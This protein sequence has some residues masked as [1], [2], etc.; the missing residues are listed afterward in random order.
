M[1]TIED[2]DNQ[3]VH[4]DVTGVLL[5]PHVAYIFQLVP[6]EGTFGAPH[7]GFLPDATLP[8]NDDSNYNG[9]AISKFDIRD[10][11]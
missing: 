1:V 10:G 8:P 9:E 5:Q 3:G 4:D 2:P 7:D 11:R 6:K